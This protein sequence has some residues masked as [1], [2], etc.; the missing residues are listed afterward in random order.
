MKSG[1]WLVRYATSEGI[2]QS[3][4]GM[5][6]RLKNNSKL[7]LAVNQLLEFYPDFSEEFR[8]FIPDIKKEF[9]VNR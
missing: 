1:N 5:S 6:R 8:Q 4:T 2:G 7:D 3:L 9:S